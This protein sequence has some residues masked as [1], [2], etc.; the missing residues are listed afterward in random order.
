MRKTIASI[1]ISLDGVVEAPY[2][3]SLPTPDDSVEE[4][5][6]AQL[7]ACDA[8]LL[9]R[10]TYEGFAQAWPNITD[11][12]GFAERMNGYPKYVVSTTLTEPAWNAEVIT[13]VAEVAK[14]KEQPGKDILI[15]GS[16]E[17]VNSL[18]KHE[19]LDELRLLINPVVAGSGKRLFPDEGELKHWRLRETKAFNLGVVL[20]AYQREA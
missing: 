19:L 11:E 7:K 1:I 18:I 8:L 6:L 3:W 9:G 16:G 10:E 20:L 4:Y 12:R 15:Y 2:K 17:L 5:A 13:D 14:L